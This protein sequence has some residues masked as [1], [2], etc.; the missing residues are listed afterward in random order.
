LLCLKYP[1]YKETKGILHCF[2]EGKKAV[3][4]L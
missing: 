4:T 3:Y 2:S 1:N